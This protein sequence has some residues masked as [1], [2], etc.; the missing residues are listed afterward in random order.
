M[1]KIIACLLICVPLFSFAQH[2]DIAP[3]WKKEKDRALIIAKMD[4]LINL[5][6]FEYDCHKSEVSYL[7]KEKY[8]FYSLNKDD[9]NFPKKVIV[10]ACRESY[11]YINLCPAN[12]YG[13]PKTWIQGKWTLIPAEEEE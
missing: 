1:K 12:S 3:G 5:V 6:S 7:V 10:R 2:A 9:H 8:K 13:K 11:E 4:E